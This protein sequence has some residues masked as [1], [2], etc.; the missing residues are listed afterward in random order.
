MKYQK[1]TEYNSKISYLLLR[2]YLEAD[3]N[4]SNLCV[5]NNDPDITQIIK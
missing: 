4:V 2:L 3:T 1:D 5:D